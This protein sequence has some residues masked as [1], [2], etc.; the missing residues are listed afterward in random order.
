VIG[1]AGPFVPPINDFKG[2]DEATIRKRVK[3]IAATTA[4]GAFLA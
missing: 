4:R 1:G 2:F 3:E